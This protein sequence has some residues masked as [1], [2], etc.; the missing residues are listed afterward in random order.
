MR[1]VLASLRLE[2][3][4]LHQPFVLGLELHQSLLRCERGHD[5]TRPAPAEGFEIL[6]PQFECL[7]PHPIQHGRDL[8]RDNVIDVADKAQRHV[9]ILG[10]DPARARKPATQQGQRLANIG[11]NFETGEEARHGNNGSSAYAYKTTR[12]DSHV[13]SGAYMTRLSRTRPT[14]SSTFG[15]MRAT[16]ASTPAAVG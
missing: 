12:G 8:V 1:R 2:P 16:M 15:R 5:R 10:V 4:P 9:I 14:S 13:S 11:G 7:P 3:N 6:H